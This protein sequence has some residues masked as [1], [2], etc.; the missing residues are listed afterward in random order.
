MF[1]I[2]AILFLIVLWGLFNYLMG[3]KKNHIIIDFDQRYTKLDEHTKAVQQELQNQGK[4]V[5][6]LGNR[7]FLIDE[8]PYIFTERTINTGGVPLQRTILVPEK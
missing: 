8:K 3:Y 5:K 4:M 1:I 7:R 2:F 6:Y